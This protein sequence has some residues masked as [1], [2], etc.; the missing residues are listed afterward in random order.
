[1]TNEEAIKV[2]IE[3]REDFSGNGEML[4]KGRKALDIAI[5]ALKFTELDF[6]ALKHDLPELFKPRYD[7]GYLIDDVPME[8]LEAGGI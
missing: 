8:Y 2:L 7:G 5:E 6:V 1:M 4:E 3:I